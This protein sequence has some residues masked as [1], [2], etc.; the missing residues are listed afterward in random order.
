MCFYGFI[1]F[2]DSVVLL[3][4]SNLCKTNIVV[5]H[6]NVSTDKS[7]GGIKSKISVIKGENTLNH[8]MYIHLSVCVC[9]HLPYV[10]TP[11]SSPWHGEPA[12]VESFP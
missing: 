11:P 5:E 4:V 12:A 7:R 9:V 10:Q 1:G 6:N 3:S 8:N 2:F